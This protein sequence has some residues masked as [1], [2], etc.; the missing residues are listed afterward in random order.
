MKFLQYR[1]KTIIPMIFSIMLLSI[2]IPCYSNNLLDNRNVLSLKSEADDSW[3]RILI[4]NENLKNP[5]MYL[6]NGDIIILGGTS[7]FPNYLRFADYDIYVAKYN[8]NGLNLWD[9]RL[10]HELYV[11]YKGF[12]VDSENNIYV[13]ILVADS[14]S[15]SYSG[16]IMLLKLDQNGEQLFVKYVEEFPNCNIDS[17]IIDLNDS[18]Y[19]TGD[20]YQSSNDY[21][22][23]IDSNGN[24]INSIFLNDTAT[25]HE[26]FIDDYNNLYVSG[27]P[28]RDYNDPSGS[29]SPL[30]KFNSTGSLL[31]KSELENSKDSFRFLNTDEQENVLAEFYQYYSINSTYNLY[32]VKLNSTGEINHEMKILSDNTDLYDVYIWNINIWY[33]NSTYL[34]Y[35]IGNDVGVE[36]YLINYDYNCNLKWNV[37][38]Q[39]YVN[40]KI[41][42]YYQRIKSTYD[43]NGSIYLVY[44]LRVGDIAFLQLNK[45]GEVT[46]HFYWGGSNDDKYSEIIIDSQDNFYLITVCEYVNIWNVYKDISIFI[47]NPLSGGYPP[48]LE[49][50][51]INMIFVISSLG[52]SSIFSIIITMEIHRKYRKKE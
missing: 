52:V 4:Q 7:D 27:S 20:D 45:F 6:M 15:F 38:I 49:E 46:S 16:K 25:D 47:K 17:M 48:S 12:V 41:L 10:E 14:S 21:L 32:L 24:F 13:S 8:T 23:K 2:S 37:S 39:Y 43:S 30:Y 42:S 11:E 50:F 28:F 18:I 26:L 36:T 31:W 51:D 22:L 34:F 40:P 44:N 9:Y 19:M 35:H 33:L 1:K 5:D 29:G 3:S